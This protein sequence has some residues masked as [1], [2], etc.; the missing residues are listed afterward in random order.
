[1]LVNYFAMFRLFSTVENMAKG[2]QGRNF[3]SF[4]L[5][6]FLELKAFSTKSPFYYRSSKAE[7]ISKK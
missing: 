1:M 5:R 7:E 6:S 2:I 4:R 3:A